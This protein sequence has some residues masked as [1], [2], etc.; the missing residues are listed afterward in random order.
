MQRVISESNDFRP[1]NIGEIVEGQ[2]I[3]REKAAVFLSLKNFGTGIIYGREFYGAKEFL[4]GLQIGD[5]LF[6]KVTEVDNPDG[7]VELSLQEAEKELG[8][9]RLKE[10]KQKEGTLKIKVLK[11]NKGGLL[12]EVEGVP[13]FIPVSQLSPE[14]YPRVEGGDQTKILKELQKLIGQELEV[15]ILT[16]D[17]RNKTIILSEK[18][19]VFERARESLKNYQAG[20]IV[21]GEVIKTTDFGVFL[22]FSV[23]NKN[24]EENSGQIEG[25]IHISELDN[26]LISDPSEVVKVGDIVKAKI[27]EIEDGRVFLSLKALK[28]EK[29]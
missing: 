12:T 27:I 28:D 11:A 14:H 21:E 7:F 17:K 29:E 15:K 4:K 22:R 9:E 13:A 1:P 18:A 23:P 16:L 6:A 24:S 3:K 26:R 10:T 19:V 25:L 2:I 8:W 5:R 20:E